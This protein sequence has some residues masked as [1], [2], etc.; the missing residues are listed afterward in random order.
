MTVIGRGF[1]AIS[2]C[3]SKECGYRVSYGSNL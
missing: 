1:E 3:K 2:R